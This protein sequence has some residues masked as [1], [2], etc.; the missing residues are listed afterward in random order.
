VPA[1]TG[2]GYELVD[3]AGRYGALDLRSELIRLGAQPS[4]RARRL[5]GRIRR[6]LRGSDSP[7]AL[8]AGMI[9]RC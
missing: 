6:R 7:H 8:D 4:G 9:G 1:R 5:A 3:F 2:A